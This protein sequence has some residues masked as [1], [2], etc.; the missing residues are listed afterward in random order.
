MMRGPSFSE[1]FESF[2]QVIVRT[3]Q[4]IIEGEK[5]H[6]IQFTDSFADMI[7]INEKQV[8]RSSQSKT[9]SLEN[10]SSVDWKPLH[11]TF[12]S[13]LTYSLPLI[14]PLADFYLV[15]RFSKRVDGSKIVSGF[16][17]DERRKEDDREKERKSL[18]TMESIS[19]TH[20]LSLWTNNVILSNVDH[21]PKNTNW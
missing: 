6:T 2:V 7:K 20:K 14:P 16:Q 3:I 10:S 15:I 21:L 1:V 5:T 18:L 17:S 4:N 12:S 19:N 8:K 11:L 9:L 13:I